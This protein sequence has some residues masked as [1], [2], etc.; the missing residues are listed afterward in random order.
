LAFFAHFEIDLVAALAEQLVAAFE[1]L[2]AGA[3][4]D[5]HVDSVPREQG[6]YQLFRNGTLVY[7]GKADALRKRLHEH[8]EKIIGRQ[9][10]R[11]D[12]MGFKCLTVHKNWTA[13]APETS[14]I[15]HYKT[16]PGICE[17]NG[18]GFGIHDPGRNRET[19]NKD[20]D[21]F[22]SQFPIKENWPCNGIA[23]KAWRVTELLAKMKKDLPFLLR[24]DTRHEDYVPLTVTV[25][26]EDMAVT[27][28]LILMTKVLPGWQSTRFP[29]HMILYKE[30]H[31]Y[32]Y[33]TVIW[34][35]PP[36]G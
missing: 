23:A 8:Q 34:R 26:K 13:L 15:F 22:D 27:D 20:P 12:E 17:W 6:V 1:K 2:D 5:E 24:Y 33:G 4:T 3:L 9:N 10:I 29:S 7:V 14:L 35:Q 11:L 28:L 21:G 19:T 31:D 25:P 36:R 18:N 32:K 30:K 16:R